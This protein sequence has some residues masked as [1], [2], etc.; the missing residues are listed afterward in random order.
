MGISLRNFTEYFKDIT[1]RMV[2]LIEVGASEL[3]RPIV[4][5][6]S[7]RNKEE[8]DTKNF[9]LSDPV[10]D[11]L[12]CVLKTLEAYRTAKVVGQEGKTVP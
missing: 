9:L 6:A 5:L 1:D 2:S 8:N 7:S 12:V 11:R 3:G 4:Y 10:D